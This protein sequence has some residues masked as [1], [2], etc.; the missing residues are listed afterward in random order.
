MYAMK[1]KTLLTLL[2]VSFHWFPINRV[3]NSRIAEKHF[4]YRY[5]R[6][7]NYNYRTDDNIQ[8]LGKEVYVCIAY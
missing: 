3:M 1:Y 5:V 7:Y 8:I 4:A 6:C 2:L